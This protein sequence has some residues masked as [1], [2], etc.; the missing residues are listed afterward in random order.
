[1]KTWSISRALAAG[2]LAFC[3]VV[4]AHR[5]A[6]A[7]EQN[8]LMDALVKGVPIE[9]PAIPPDPVGQYQAEIIN[10]AVPSA[11]ALHIRFQP[12]GAQSLLEYTSS[13]PVVDALKTPSAR[14]PRPEVV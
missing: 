7:A 1:M 5:S 13:G 8:A 12:D 2:L 3:I 4:P 6:R 9:A 10:L 11:R 14:P